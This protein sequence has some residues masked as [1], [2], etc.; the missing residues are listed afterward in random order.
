MAYG[1]C[2]DE[3]HLLP[4]QPWF[5]PFSTSLC[6][7]PS[8]TPQHILFL[9]LLSIPLHFFLANSFRFQH[10]HPRNL[11]QIGLDV[12]IHISTIPFAHFPYNIT[13]II[14]SHCFVITCLSP[15]QIIKSFRVVGP[16]SLV[17]HSV[18][19]TWYI[20]GTTNIC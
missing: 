8:S 6:T 11:S 17:H 18:P 7:Q 15:P 10:E 4:L 9:D 12:P 14:L 1:V 3:N 13:I 16:C 2:Y 5:S 19:R 20:L